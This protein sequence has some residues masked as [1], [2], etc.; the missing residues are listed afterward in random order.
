MFNKVGT[1]GLFLPGVKYRVEP[2][3]GISNGGLLHIAGPNLMKQYLGMPPLGNSYYNTGDIVSIDTDGFITIIGRL[4]RFAKIH[5]EMVDLTF[6]ESLVQKIWDNFEHAAISKP[7]KLG[8][9]VHLFTTSKDVTLDHI[10]T[11]VKKHHYSIL[12]VPK[13]I[14]IVEK[15]P[16]LGSGKIDYVTL[17]KL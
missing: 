10:A 2:I 13:K 14:H 9:E 17:S 8:E 7:T 16:R 11:Y 5:G 6:L 1:V 3:E 15:M 12:M 4:K